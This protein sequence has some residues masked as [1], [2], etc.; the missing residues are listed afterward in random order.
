MSL[1]I[2]SQSLLFLRHLRQ[3]L[4]EKKSNSV[5]NCFDSAQTMLSIYENLAV[6]CRPGLHRHRCTERKQHNRQPWNTY[7]RSDDEHAE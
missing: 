5:Y 2:V 3:I 6:K 4:G 7:K 1:E